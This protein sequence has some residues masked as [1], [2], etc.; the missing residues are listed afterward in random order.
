MRIL[1]VKD[2]KKSFQNIESI[3]GKNWLEE[4]LTRIA[5][6]K[7][8]NTP[9][10]H[11]FLRRKEEF[12]PFIPRLRNAL[13]DWER[14][15]KSRYLKVTQDLVDVTAFGNYLGRLK[16]I[17]I[18]DREGTVIDESS[19]RKLTER[20]K[21]PR[22]FEKARYEL[23]IAS[24]YSLRYNQVYFILESKKWRAKT[25]DLH[26]VIDGQ[27]VQIECKKKDDLTLRD[28]KNNEVWRELSVK[29]LDL[30][31]K[32]RLSYLVILRFDEDPIYDQLETYFSVAKKLI[33][34]DG[35][36][37]RKARGLG[38]AVEIQRIAKYDDFL[39]TSIF[40]D[41]KRQ[42][43][44]D[45]ETF[46]CFSDQ[47]GITQDSVIKNLKIVCFKSKQLPDRIRGV[48]RSFRKAKLQMGHGMPGLIYVELN[49]TNLKDSDFVIM[50]KEIAKRFESNINAAILT[51]PPLLSL[52]EKGGIYSHKSKV[53]EN[54][55]ATIPLSEK[56]EI[57]GY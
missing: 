36:N 52:D 55:Y 14:C 53:I 19:E 24:A 31:T 47:K 40:K 37:T 45:F 17:G 56:F 13:A 35:R 8:T 43:Y 34:K 51:R 33:E 16:C 5:S 3:F 4:E 46:S 18:V 15:L 22:S 28:K 27:R 23:Q 57:I 44:F 7:P 9:T 42:E 26:V 39:T 6:R 41:L 20:L 11:A 2:I 25:P 30:M 38:F 54:P 29:L 50:E 12:H 49:P 48:V 1:D 32:K 10:T 21:N